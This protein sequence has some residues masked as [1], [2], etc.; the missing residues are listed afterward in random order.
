[1]SCV[2]LVGSRR[3]AVEAVRRLGLRAV[4]VAD[5][6]PG[7]RTAALVADVVETPFDAPLS[8]WQ[9]LAET[10]R[11]H[12]PS[13]VLALTERAVLPA[14]HLRE[15]LGLDGVSVATARR[16]THKGAMKRAVR[17]AGLA[18]ADFVLAEEGLGREALVARL[19]LPLVVKPCV[20][21]GGRGTEVVRERG[22]VPERLPPGWM[23][24]AF[25]TGTEMS[26]EGIG[27]GGQMRWMSATDYVVPCEASLVPAPLDPGAA[28]AIRRLHG[29]AWRA[30]GVERGLTH[31]EVFLGPEGPVFGELAVRPPGGHLMRLIGLAYGIDAWEA[32]V[33]VECGEPVALPERARRSAA[34]WIWHPGA[35]VVQEVEGVDAVQDLPGVVEATVRVAP[36]DAVGPR[37]GSGQEV[38]HVVVTGE[39]PDEAR[40][41]LD[42]A[43]DAVRIAIDPAGIERA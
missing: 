4:L 1:M 19:G 3:P 14:A 42:A 27:W 9:A 29:A 31:L 24:E 30:L 7:S 33:R 10:L 43:R 34:V 18:C 13:A 21:S 20:G 17:D 26:A 22:D 8:H 37:E 40:A 36:G 25:V 16:C 11:R 39:A 28:S 15:A 38:G 23:A 41:R 5:R 2:V 32:W 6:A 12:R 35:G